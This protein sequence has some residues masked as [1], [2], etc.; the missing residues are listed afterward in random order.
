MDLQAKKL[1]FI[2][3]ILASGNEKLIDKLASILKKERK[4][5][6]QQ[7]SVYDLLGVISEKEAENMKKD[8]EESCEKIHE[9]DW[10]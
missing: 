5:G 9:E 1:N 2:Q 10:K 3:E 4:K 8:I 6:S 7:P